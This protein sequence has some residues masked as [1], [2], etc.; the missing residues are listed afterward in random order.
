M[1]QKNKRKILN[2]TKKQKKER[3]VKKI[4]KKTRYLLKFAVLM[5]NFGQNAIFLLVY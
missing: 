1:E 2:I 5:V 3:F 4:A